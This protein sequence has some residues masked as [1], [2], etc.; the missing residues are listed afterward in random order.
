MLVFGTIVL[1]LCNETNY[2]YVAT[3]KESKRFLCFSQQVDK[4][5]KKCIKIARPAVGFLC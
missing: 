1:S 5:C 2:F 4:F 3:G